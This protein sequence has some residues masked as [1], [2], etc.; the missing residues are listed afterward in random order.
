MW[1][2][3]LKEVMNRAEILG[4]GSTRAVD[5]ANSQAQIARFSVMSR[6]S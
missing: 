1:H 4:T 3:Q 2:P 5:T 6:Y